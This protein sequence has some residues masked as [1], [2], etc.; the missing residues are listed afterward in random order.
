[1]TVIEIIEKLKE[2]PQDAECM[3]IWDGAAR[4]EV[5]GVYLARNGKVMFIDEDVV[6]DGEER[7]DYAP[8]EAE[9]PYWHFSPNRV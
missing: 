9:D 4:S 6:Y 5:A 8:T 7:P 1:M 3:Y 2:M